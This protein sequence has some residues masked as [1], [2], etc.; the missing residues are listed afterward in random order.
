MTLPTRLVEIHYDQTRNV[1]KARL[2]RGNLLPS[3]TAYVA[4]S[5]CWGKAKFFNLTKKNYNA[6]MKIFPMEELPRKFL[7]AFDIASKLGFHHIWI[8]SLCIVQDS[9]D[10]WKFESSRMGEVYQN[11]ALTLS[12]SESSSAL[13]GCYKE[14]QSFGLDILTDLWPDRTPMPV[15]GFRI[16]KRDHY[17]TANQVRDTC[18]HSRGWTIQERALSP[19]ILHFT[20]YG[21]F[22]ECEHCTRSEMAQDGS[23]RGTTK[24][25]LA[26]RE[27]NGD[28]SLETIWWEIVDQYTNCELTHPGK[29]KLVAISGLA[30]KLRNHHPDQ[31]LAGLWK[32]RLITDLC[33][34]TF[35]PSTIRPS[36]YRA[37]SWSWASIDSPV[38]MMG[39]SSVRK[40]GRAIRPFATITDAKTSP[41]ADD[42]FGQLLGGV[43]ELDCYVLPV[44]LPQGPIK[45]ETFITML[46]EPPLHVEFLY[47]TVWDDGMQ[48]LML[49]QENFYPNRDTWCLPL[50]GY[51]DYSSRF[52]EVEQQAM[53]D[54]LYPRIKAERGEY[55]CE[56]YLGVDEV[57]IR[58]PSAIDK[59]A[60][61]QASNVKN[62]PGE[63]SNPDEEESRN[64][65][66]GD[67]LDMD[68]EESEDD[69]SEDEEESEDDY[70]QDEESGDDF[71]EDEHDCSEEDGVSMPNDQS[72]PRDKIIFLVIEPVEPKDPEPTRF[73]R[74]GLHTVFLKE[75][76]SV[77]TV[78]FPPE[79]RR[80]RVRLV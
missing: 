80:E 68:E 45:A 77:D 59:T 56:E 5:H 11:A 66:S 12:A 47:E 27:A 37:P 74:I 13:E 25:T 4:L 40:T 70:S 48:S 2:V 34:A 41:V 17:E 43:L 76:S 31:Y 73:R 7:E 39:S 35:E 6:S 36:E 14:R 63:H 3:N 49:D 60:I 50:L 16:S 24:L 18:I 1:M 28:S 22:W 72:K 26:G 21:I 54:F 19:R 55:Y 52:S 57:A 75:G 69:Y 58:D 33:W 42:E 61:P 51:V 79:F 8:D 65:G 44:S 67:Y 71:E 38:E 15:N 9:D 78:S 53:C 64:K 23:S 32:S 20:H 62:Q 29:D 10:D 46:L 30:K